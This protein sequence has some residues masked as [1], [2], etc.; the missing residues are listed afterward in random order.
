MMIAVGR[1]SFGTRV[2][3]RYTTVW[4]GTLPYWQRTDVPDIVLQAVIAVN[5]GG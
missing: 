2:A 5:A 3:L 4:P 1:L